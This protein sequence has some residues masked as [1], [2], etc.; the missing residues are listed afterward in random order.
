MNSQLTKDQF[1][2][3]YQSPLILYI[4][5]NALIK[6]GLRFSLFEGVPSTYL[7]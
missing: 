2:L 1:N 6:L 7:S 3:T 5:K 4:K